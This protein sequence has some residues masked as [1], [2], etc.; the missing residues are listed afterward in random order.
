MGNEHANEAPS[1]RYARVM[2]PASLDLLRRAFRRMNQGMVLLWRLGLGR[3]AGV[4]PRGFGRLLVIEHTGRRSGQPYRTP[5]NYAIVGGDLFCVAAF[6]KRTDWYRN[7]L[8][9]SEIAVWL[10]DGRWTAQAVDVSADPERLDLMRRV[11]LDSGFAAPLFGLHPR[12][13]SDR[14]LAEAT[15][16]YL[17]VRITPM[18]KQPAATGPADLLWVWIPL[19]VVSWAVWRLRTYR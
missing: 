8:T 13:M 14:A 5:V 4:W 19:A 3:M 12:R 16:G 2:S 10:P 7:I 9:A 18:A 6:G 1:P 17:L 15:R 11:L